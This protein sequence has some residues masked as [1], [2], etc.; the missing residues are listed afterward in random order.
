MKGE[1]VV[2]KVKTIEVT[3][4]DEDDKKMVYKFGGDN[5]HPFVRIGYNVQ[6]GDDLV[7]AEYSLFNPHIEKRTTGFIIEY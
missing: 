1:A 2:G 3:I 5:F 7:M 6:Y 4:V